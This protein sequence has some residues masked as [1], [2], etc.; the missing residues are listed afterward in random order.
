MLQFGLNL[1]KPPRLG[2]LPLQGA[3]LPLHFL[4][5]VGDA[6]Q[7]LLGVLQLAQR[8][9][10]LRFEFRDPRRLLENHPPVFRLAR[11]NLRD[12][13]LRQDAVARPPNP[14]A[15]EQLLDVL[16][17]ARRAIQKI[18]APAITKN[19]PRQRHF[20]VTHFDPRRLQTFFADAAQRE[21]HFAHAQRF[22]AVR[23]VEYHI[24][25]LA[26]AQGFGRLLAEHPADGVGDVGLAAAVRPDDG[27]D[28]RLKV[29]RGLV[30]EGLKAEY[31]EILEIHLIATASQP[32]PPS[33]VKGKPQ[34]VVHNP[35][36]KHHPL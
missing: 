23:A 18:F 32:K 35:T 16:Q 33:P 5:R 31:C 22:P 15:Q 12:V 13:P 20:I 1:L 14:R 6:Q 28:P 17:P 9:L 10:L 25:H 4:N 3:N 8:F 36:P 19:P 21:R 30:R 26:A 27:R 7:V 24:R 29:Q 34:Q 11:Q 2:G